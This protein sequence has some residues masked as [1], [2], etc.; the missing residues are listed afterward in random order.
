MGFHNSNLNFTDFIDKFVDSNNVAD[1][2]IDSNANSNTHDI[3][4]LMSGYDETTYKTIGSEQNFFMKLLRSTDC[5]LPKNGW[6]KNGAVD[7]I[8]MI[9][10]QQHLCH[11]VLRMISRML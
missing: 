7:Y 5:K 11:T 9:F 10:H 6:N 3:R 8:F 4:T 1:V 2:T